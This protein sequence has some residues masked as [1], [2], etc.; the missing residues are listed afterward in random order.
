MASMFVVVKV[1]FIYM[2]SMFVVV[3]VIFT[4]MVSVF[5]VIRVIFTCMALMFVVLKVI[6]TCM[7]TMFGVVKVKFTCM[8]SMLAVARVKGAV[9][10]NTPI[11]TGAIRESAISHSSSIAMVIS[12]LKARLHLTRGWQAVMLELNH[13]QRSSPTPHRSKVYIT[14][15]RQR[16]SPTSYSQVFT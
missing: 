15:Q 11:L 10:R 12:A 7:T 1:I 4:Y 13:R 16:S 8:A 3:K 6:F 2:A 9:G 5:G 14:I